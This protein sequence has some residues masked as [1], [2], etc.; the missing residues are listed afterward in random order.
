MI[1]RPND[2]E[3]LHHV[4]QQ[5]ACHQV[6][7]QS[8]NNVERSGGTQQLPRQT[9]KLNLTQDSTNITQYPQSGYHTPRQT[10]T[11]M[12]QDIARPQPQEPNRFNPGLIPHTD[13]AQKHT[14]GNHL[15]KH[16][17]HQPEQQYEAAVT[18]HV[19]PQQSPC[20]IQRQHPQIPHSFARDQQQ[21]QQAANKAVTEKNGESFAQNSKHEQL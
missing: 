15:L 11:A 20:H 2:A 21:S 13:H 3:T 12:Q 5:Q 17:T 1:T 10:N 16:R 18:V 14:Q 9:G 8:H 7:I 19:N 4:D 6:S